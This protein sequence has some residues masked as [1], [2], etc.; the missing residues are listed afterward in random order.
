MI[1]GTSMKAMI[2]ISISLEVLLAGISFGGELNSAVINDS[3]SDASTQYL[4][5]DIAG[6][7]FDHTESASWQ[8]ITSYRIGYGHNLA[9]PLGI[10][11]FAEYFEF[12][13]DHHDGTSYH[14]YSN[15]KRYDYAVYPAIVLFD[16]AEF[17]LGAYYTT[18]GE[19]I[20]RSVFAPQLTIDPAVKR[21]KIFAHLGIGWS[22]HIAGPVSCSLGMVLRNDL[23]GSK[24]LG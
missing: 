9:Y 21:I 13:F 19:I 18:Q 5:V 14:D 10:R 6:F 11:V 12:D 8:P 22:F 3:I 17:A 2:A 4:A 16:I 7:P 23:E 20:H 15:G 1:Y 24:Y